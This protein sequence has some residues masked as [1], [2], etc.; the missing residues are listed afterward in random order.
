MLKN[1]SSWKVSLRHFSTRASR[2]LSCP[3]QTLLYALKSLPS[4]FSTTPKHRLQISKRLTGIE[5]QHVSD[6]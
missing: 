5:K 6:G 4:A 1:L 3:T 2:T